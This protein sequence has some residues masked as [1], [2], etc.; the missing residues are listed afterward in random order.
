MRPSNS[1]VLGELRARSRGNVRSEL[2]KSGGQATNLTRL[3]HQNLRNE[4]F[5]HLDYAGGN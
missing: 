5:A 1:P 3:S 2:H 4:H